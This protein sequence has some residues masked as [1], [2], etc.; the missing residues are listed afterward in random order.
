[1]SN[2]RFDWEVVN[3]VEVRAVIGRNALRMND[4]S[5]CWDEVA[6]VAGDKAVLLT[7]NFDTD[8][9]IVDYSPCPQGEDWAPITPLQIVVGMPLG[10]CWEMSNYLGYSDGFALAFGGVLPGALE[11]KMTFIAAGSA[12]S[13]LMMAAV[14]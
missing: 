9:I 13:C 7:V 14:G 1:M 5:L 12:L 6:F 8:E 10:W 3:G 2:L 4:G 11:P